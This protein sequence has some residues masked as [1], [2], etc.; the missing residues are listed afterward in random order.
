[1]KKLSPFIFQILFICLISS[2]ITSASNSPNSSSP[3]VLQAIAL[4]IE[5]PVS[6]TESATPLCEFILPDYTSLALITGAGAAPVITQSPLASS[7]YGLGTITVTLTANDGTS[8][9]SCS[10]DVQVIDTTSPSL[11]CPVDQF[12]VTDE[13]C[14]FIIPDY[15][16]LGSAVDFCSAGTIPVTQ[17]PPAGTVVSQNTM[18]FLLATD[19]NGNT[20]A[21]SFNV[22]ISDVI[23]PSIVCPQDR[24]EVATLECL[25]TIPD[26]TP[27]ANAN[28]NCATVLLTQSPA[29]GTQVS[30]GDTQITL[31]ASD[32]PNTTSCTFN[33]TVLDTSPPIVSCPEDQLEDYD[34]NCQFILPDYTSLAT[35]TDT[36]Y[37]GPFTVT[38]VPAPGTLISGNVSVAINATD[39]AGNTGSCSFMVLQNDVIPPTITCPSNQIE[40]VNAANCMFIIP[41]YTALA[42]AEDGCNDDLIITQSPPAGTQVGLG[43][44]TITLTANDGFNTADCTFE[45]EVQN[46]TT[47]NAVCSAP[48]NL[49]LD[50]D[51]N[52]TLTPSQVDGGSNAFCDIASM[53]IDLT[54]FNCD[55][56]GPHQV[57]LTIIDTNGNTS[58]CT[59]IVTI[60]DPLFACNELPIALCQALVVS[61]NENCQGEATAQD[62][63]NGSFDPDNMPFT[64]TVSPQGPYPLGTTTVVLTI[65]DGEYTDSCT[66][67]ITVVDTTAPS[68]TCLDNQIVAVDNN[69]SYVVPNYLSQVTAQDNCA[70][71]SLEQNPLP[72]TVIA[73]GVT[74]VTITASDGT[75]QTLC[76]FNLTVIDQTAPTAVCQSITVALDVNGTATITSTDIDGGSTDNCGTITTSLNTTI[77]SCDDIGDNTVLLTITDQA[78]Q[79][80]T[81]SAIVTVVDNLAPQVVC[82]DITLILGPTGQATISAQ[83]I[84]A[85][86]TDNCGIV[87]YSIDTT[88]F[89]CSNTGA[90]VVT[91]TLTDASGNTSSCIT[92]VT[93][94]DQTP[95]T[96]TCLEDQI[97]AI[98]NTCSFVVPNYVPSLIASDNCNTLSVT[99]NPLPGTILGVGTT[100]VT[101]TA[102]DGSFDTLCNFN[103][104][105]T[106]QTAP[107]AICQNII[108][109]LDQ[110]GLATISSTDIDFGS[111]DNCG[112]ITASLDITTFSCN[113]IGDN[114]VA[115]TITDQGGLV[116][117]CNAIVTVVD[118]L[119]PQ[120]LT[121]DST[122][123]L[124][125]NGQVS[126]TPQD[127]DAGSTDNCGIVSSTIDITSFDCSNIGENTVTLTLIDASGNIATATATITVVDA[128][129][130]TAVCQ[131]ITISLDASGNASI[132]PQDIDAGSF[133]NCDASQ[134]AISQTNFDC[135]TIGENQVVFT[136]TDPSGNSSSCTA[137]VTVENN[138]VPVA[139]CQNITLQLDSSGSATISAADL[140]GGSTLTCS[141]QATIELD[142]YTFD[143]NDI[144]VNEVAFTIT[145]TNGLSTSCTALVTVEDTLAPTVVCQDIIVTLDQDGLA[146]IEIADIN[147]G[148]FDACGIAGMSLD[149]DTFDC[150]MIGTNPVTLSVTDVNGNSSACQATVTVVDV[151]YPTAMCQSITLILDENGLATITA[152]DLDQGSS[153]NCSN[154]TTSVNIDTFDCSN[155]GQNNVL[156]TVTDMQGNASSCNATVTIV[157][158]TAPVKDCQDITVSLEDDLQISLTL[159]ELFAGW[160]DNCAIETR[161]A[162]VTSFDCSNIGENTVTLTAIDSSGNEAT[163]SII[164]NIQEGVFAPVAVCQN[165]T[166]PLQQDG[167]ASIPASSL[168]GGSSGVRCQDGY[169]VNISEFS[170]S[171]VGTPILVEF[172]VYNSIGESDTC[173]AYV[174]VIDGLAPE[175][176][177][178]ADQTIT[179]EGA[180]SLPDYFATGEALALDNCSTTLVTDQSPNPG[181]ILEDGT[182]TITLSATDN[183]G[184]EST[185]EF[186]IVVNDLLSNQDTEILLQDIT[187]Y[188]NPASDTITITNPEFVGL[189]NVTIYDVAGR[190]VKQNN[191]SGVNNAVVMNISQLRSAVY[192]VVIT[193]EYGQLVKQLLKK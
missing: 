148:S 193:T 162:D 166:V 23:A 145:Q 4:D 143:C 132:T 106:D 123:F 76:T 17:N 63:D 11:T 55:D 57:T 170:C 153:D 188:P 144:G 93:V 182:H 65:N 124:D 140:D 121:Q 25:F 178:P 122:V 49:P 22:I 112:S 163:C 165:V 68:L 42:S 14:E 110:N 159:D 20:G 103:I 183:G 129:A 154:F 41:D 118:T 79:T 128:T 186:E 46:T 157:D 98:D 5:C 139:A 169:S 78:G 66:T 126:I 187:I 115:L 59:T 87:S 173:Y 92:T 80:T 82:Q 3:N 50:A 18:I 190:L 111:S 192:M 136:I 174:N 10:F 56:L 36:C 53:G 168:D 99:Q 86:S 102:T 155:V 152:S 35:I 91:L 62:F 107:T 135:S 97:V 176:T 1:M 31:T 33:I 2:A 125:P 34:V 58:S 48:F 104:I 64:L 146:F 133:D 69:C 52:A 6:F 7:L 158:A 74:L 28:D 39:N 83:D 185:C 95:P 171:D 71:V 90:N 189:N 13:N 21:C 101:V 96:L 164:I 44:T 142:Q 19:S 113:D 119:A 24:E 177:C 134:I 84:D 172:T 130:P 191:V 161:T 37:P 150:S 105:V 43:F 117:T 108:L 54:D 26:Y 147:A 30:I 16:P 138:N 61:A 184:F 72:G 156:F 94:V 51:G 137:M 100:P 89:D 60:T 45:I 12:A 160:S 9:V 27:L 179:S 32:G 77:F 116:S 81:C 47:P 15:T 40:E 38:Q 180:Y 151:T 141:Q 67:T 120:I 167:T 127:I 149:T 8:E 70:V 75:N 85:G 131:N 175:I 73:P 181:T 109:P 114:L 88:T 29:V